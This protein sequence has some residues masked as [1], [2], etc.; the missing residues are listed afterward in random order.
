MDVCTYLVTALQLRECRRPIAPSFVCCFCIPRHRACRQSIPPARRADAAAPFPR[1]V[2]H[3]VVQ[4]APGRPCTMIVGLLLSGQ[5]WG[6]ER[7]FLLL[8]SI[9]SA[10]AQ[11]KVVIRYLYILS[12]N[13]RIIVRCHLTTAQHNHRRGGCIRG[14]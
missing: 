9:I 2:P 5:R 7:I 6:L 1:L 3:V 4:S 11:S 10:V 13:T 14:F 12:I 8:Y